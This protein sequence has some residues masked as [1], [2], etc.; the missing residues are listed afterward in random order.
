[1]YS[2]KQQTIKCWAEEDRPRE[3]LISKGKSN[4]SDAELVAI[5]LGSGSQDL[6]ALDLAKHILAKHQNDLNLLSKTNVDEFCQFKGIGPAKAVSLVACLE[7]G[8]RKSSSQSKKKRQIKSSK[9]AFDLL[10]PLC[11]DAPNEKFIV[12]HLSQSNQ[13]LFKSII[14]IGGVAA[15]VVDP[16]M[17]F[18][19]ALDKRAVSI[20]LCHNH[21]SGN[22]KPS[23]ADLDITKK[24]VSGG[25]MLDINVLDHLIIGD[26]QYFSFADEGL[27]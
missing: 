26:D 25:K 11:Q 17:I 12:L 1:M 16:K 9:D 7:L 14:S 8:R 2:N 21:P 5:I 4:L 10:A 19:E 18:K 24:L 3:K 20:I 23:Q 6:T 15:T 13:A 22:L 27:I